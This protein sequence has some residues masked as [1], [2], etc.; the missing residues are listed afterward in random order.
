MSFTTGSPEPWGHWT[1]SPQPPPTYPGYMHAHGQ[2]LGTWHVDET[3]VRALALA[4]Y[5]HWHLGTAQPLAGL[6][7]AP[8]PLSLR[9]DAND[10]GDG[11]EADPDDHAGH[12]GIAQPLAGVSPAPPP[13]DPAQQSHPNTEHWL[14]YGYS[15]H[16]MHAVPPPHLGMFQPLAGLSEIPIP[17][18]TP[19]P[20]WEAT[21]AADEKKADPDDIRDIGVD[22]AYH[23]APN[24]HNNASRP[25]T[26][27]ISQGGCQQ[28]VPYWDGLDVTPVL[29]PELWRPQTEED[30]A[31]KKAKL[32]AQ[33]ATQHRRLMAQLENEA[34]ARANVD[35]RAKENAKA[36]AKAYKKAKAK[37]RRQRLGA[38]ARQ[39]HGDA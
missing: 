9:P 1:P 34:N 21:P 24:R 28:R 33:A 17:P 25:E 5:T 14:A 2:D 13:L 26:M 29:A 39:G 36:K 6:S 11:D 32:L 12:L 16:V 4:M 15:P 10:T 3:R 8:P 38:E 35:A 27:L 22:H 19:P 37:V 30:K 7:P 20:Q 18:P 23:V 31:K